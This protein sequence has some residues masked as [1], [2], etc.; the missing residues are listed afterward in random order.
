MPK[1]NTFARVTVHIFFLLQNSK[2]I[3]FKDNFIYIAKQF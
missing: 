1:T 3:S 2:G